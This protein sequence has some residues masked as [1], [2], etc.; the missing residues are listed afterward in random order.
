[1]QVQL[2]LHKMRT[3]QN[4]LDSSGSR[5]MR[6][7]KCFTVMNEIKTSGWTSINLPSWRVISLDKPLRTATVIPDPTPDGP[8]LSSALASS[9][10]LRL[11]TE[12]NSKQPRKEVMLSD[13]VDWKGLFAG[14]VC[15]KD[16]SCSSVVRRSQ[17]SDLVIP[18]RLATDWKKKAIKW[19][20]KT[21]TTKKQN[22]KSPLSTQIVN[23]M[24]LMVKIELALNIFI[25][26]R[27]LLI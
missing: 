27:F 15:W 24:V 11:L 5:A 6:K 1:M 26:Y 8:S 14:G 2:V 13:T 22:V 19:K 7:T 18:R 21:T 16:W 23:K 10:L 3:S 9:S 20:K 12:A 17:T 4:W 25:S